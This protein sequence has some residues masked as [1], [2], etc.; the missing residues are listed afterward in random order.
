MT[1]NYLNGEDG[2]EGEGAV[3]GDAGSST[4]PWY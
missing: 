3:P 4:G 2:R 1:S